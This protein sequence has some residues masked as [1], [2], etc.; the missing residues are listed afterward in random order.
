METFVL[1]IFWLSL[2]GFFL[3]GLTM[4]FSDY[5]RNQEFKLQFDIA[6]LILKIPFLIWAAYILWGN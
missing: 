4:A 6:R 3:I 1:V 2:T 5:P